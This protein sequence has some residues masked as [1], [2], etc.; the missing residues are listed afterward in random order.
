MKIVGAEKGLTKDVWNTLNVNGVIS[1]SEE[2]YRLV[3]FGG[4]DQD[5]R[6]EVWPFLLGHYAFGS[7]A[8]ERAELDETSR[9]YYETT[10]SEW[11][12]VEAIVRQRDKEKTAVAVAKLSSESCGENQKAKQAQLDADNDI[13]ND[14]FEENGFSD[15]SD[16][17][18]YEIDPEKDAKKQ[19]VETPQ[20]EIVIEKPS[21]A[22]KSSTDSGNVADG[23]DEENE[24][25]EKVEKSEK[26]PESGDEAQA[27]QLKAE[28]LPEL[29][30]D[31]DGELFKM[32]VE[33]P[34]SNKSTPST[35]S[36]ETVANDFVD[37]TAQIAEIEANEINIT[38]STTNHPHAVIVTDAS[39]DIA[40]V[41]RA[42]KN[43]ENDGTEPNESNLSP[44]QEEVTGHSSL[45]AL[46]EP[47][48][49]CVSPA[50]SNGGIYSVS[51]K[52]KFRRFFLVIFFL[53][54]SSFQGELLETFGL[55]LHRIE[56]DVQ[57][58]DRNYWYFANENLD[59]LRNVICT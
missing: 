6:K 15:M 3:Y 37:L 34:C 30:L 40:N 47:K 19:I 56:K 41:Q 1:D 28:N 33:E 29:N 11:L 44:L 52:M 13:E 46:Q 12:A 35:S 16:Q 14:V 23:A 9:H 5:I 22:N 31:Q 45:D 57:R 43:D 54:P 51:L 24:P 26:V 58:C 32:A 10:M 8:E 27:N 49:A 17:D 50:S 48:S 18:E 55:N 2:V 42:E 4:C 21:R 39:I 36:Y 59:K 53:L 38:S 20:Q 7:T 25:D